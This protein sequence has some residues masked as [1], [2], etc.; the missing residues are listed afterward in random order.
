[1]GK[2]SK[3]ANSIVDL[4]GGNENIQS[5]THCITRLRFKLKDENLADDDQ[6]SKL[7]GVVTVV[8]AGGQYQVV[9]GNH[10]GL[11]YEEIQGSVS[12]TDTEEEVKGSFFAKLI[13]IISACFSPIL[14][15]LCATG[16]IKGINALMIAV[17]AYTVTDGTY[18][19]LNAI[20]DSFFF[21]LPVLLGYTS[22]QKFKVNPF[23]GLAIGLS[24]CYPSIQLNVLREGAATIGSVM[25]IDYYQTFL[26][27]P[28]VGG[29]YTGTVIPVLFMMVLAAQIQKLM[30]KIVPE[31]I[32]SFFVP[33]FVLIITLPIGF[34]VIGPIVSLLTDLLGSGFMELYGISPIVFALLV[35]FAWQI[36]VIFGLHWSL[37]PI[38][39]LNISTYGSDYIS[40]AI[41]ST[42]F[43]QTGVVL[44]MYFKLRDQKLKTL[45]IPAL[46]SGLCGV[47]E[48]AIYGLTLPKKKPFIYSLIGASIGGGISGIA[49]ARVYM[50]GGTGIFGLPQFISPEGSLYSL[51][52]M[53]V[54]CAVALVVGFLLTF[55]LWSDKE[56][57]EVDEKKKSIQTGPTKINSPISGEV[58]PLSRASDPVFSGGMM[59]K[60]VL[61]LPTDESVYSPIEGIVATLF[62]TLHAIGLLGDDGLE[63]LIHIGM[64]TVE[65]NGEGFDAFV[66][67]GDRVTKGQLLL[68]FDR[69]LIQSKNYL[70]ETPVVVTNSSTYENFEVD[71]DES[72]SAN[73]TLITVSL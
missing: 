51:V 66:S 24:M 64:N 60:G 33:F 73:Q 10:V 69:E 46:V 40:G 48:P 18:L 43:A 45:C 44:A 49:G 4:V 59:G 7:E 17:G 31:L 8:H 50:M 36:M 1:M 53:V 34:L 55:L 21:F 58:K 54:S 61:I 3:L 11:V 2:Y 25:G 14:S 22:A 56:T 6:I 37:V 38:F 29:N 13:D 9:I 68:K 12:N 27:L 23:V 26:G 47:T 5:L 72:I 52:W 57:I 42:S 39:L 16:M 65:L 41:F 19:I 20:G 32:Q 67:Q 62:P 71:A 70:L 35:G 30:K 28:F 63:I 15:V